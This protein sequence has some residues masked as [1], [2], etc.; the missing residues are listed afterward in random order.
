MTKGK[1]IIRK[2]K[3]QK[4][5]RNFRRKAKGNSKTGHIKVIAL[6]RLA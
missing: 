2:E 1:I 6:G 5:K 4:R 3:N